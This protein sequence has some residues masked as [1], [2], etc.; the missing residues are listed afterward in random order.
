MVTSLPWLRNG[1]VTK[2][3][4]RLNVEGN[5]KD[6][7]KKIHW[8]PKLDQQVTPVI[9]REFDHLVTKP[10]MEDEDDITALINP[11]SVVNTQAIGDPLLKTLPKGCKI[12]LERRGYYIVDRP[13]FQPGRQKSEPMVLVKI[14]DGKSKDMG[15]KSKVDPSK[16]Q[17]AAGQKGEKG[18]KGKAVAD[19]GASPKM[20]GKN[21][22]ETKEPK[23]SKA[24]APKVDS[25][26]KAKAKAAAK[27]G[28]RPLEDF[29]RPQKEGPF[30]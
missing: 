20:N 25:K 7:K 23:D 3:T 22:S 13:A 8:V 5:V 15:M 14:P 6:T 11:A 30:D 12:Q 17:G 9:L 2:L 18:E 4:G 19:A 29:S 21:G 10:K 27:P 16:L 1:K 28:D 26:D 24:E